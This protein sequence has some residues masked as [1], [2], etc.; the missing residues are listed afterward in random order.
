M[1]KHI[2]DNN[3]D[4]SLSLF[5]M[6]LYYAEKKSLPNGWH[7]GLEDGVQKLKSIDG[8]KWNKINKYVR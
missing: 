6:V 3:G 5:K 8:D 2:N 1:L 4:I 7:K